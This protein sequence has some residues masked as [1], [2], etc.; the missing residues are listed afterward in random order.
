MKVSNISKYYKQENKAFDIQSI[1]KKE[2]R[3]D[4]PTKWNYTF[5]MFESVLF[6][7]CAFCHLDLSNS[8]FKHCLSTSKCIRGLVLLGF[9]D[10]TCDFSGTNYCTF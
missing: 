10:A 3:Q 1:N 8:N 2:L 9:Y 6:Y 7:H 5:P 4:V